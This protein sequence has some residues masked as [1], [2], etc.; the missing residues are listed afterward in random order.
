MKMFVHHLFVN[1]ST[2]TQTATFLQQNKDVLIIFIVISHSV[3][4]QPAKKSR[5]VG[6]CEQWVRR[7]RESSGVGGLITL[8]PHTKLLH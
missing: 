8:Q 6:C 4:L 2:W 5:Q 1:V 7:G 3:V